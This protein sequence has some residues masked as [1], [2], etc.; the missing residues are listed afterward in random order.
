MNESSK[1]KTGRRQFLSGMIPACALTCMAS[2]G[3]FGMMAPR[4]S[5]VA[6]PDK[7]KFDHEVE[8][9]MTHRNQ[10]RAR[11]SE[12]FRLVQALLK[13]WDREKLVAFLKKSTTEHMLAYGKRH[14]AQV[15]DDSFAAYVNTFRGPGFE[16]S[17]TLEIVE[18]TDTVFEIKVTECLWA[19]TFLE[20]DA[21]DIGYAHVCFGDYAWAEGY[22]PRIEMVR[23]HTLMQG[24]AYCNHRY[25]WKG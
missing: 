11:Y 20:A 16:N 13:E 18:D 4:R 12:F 6:L 19:S 8:K 17:L 1:H 25:L 9:K 5:P 23:D 7:H 2:G 22:N 21:G 24:H 10:V 14:A 15:G 3:A